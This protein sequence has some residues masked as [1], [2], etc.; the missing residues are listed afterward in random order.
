MLRLRDFD[1]EA[2]EE[3]DADIQKERLAR[4]ESYRRQRRG[5]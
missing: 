4:A 1:P 5:E 2:Q 3:I